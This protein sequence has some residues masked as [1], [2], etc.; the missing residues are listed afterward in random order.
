MEKTP[1]VSLLLTGDSKCAMMRRYA[2]K[3]QWLAVGCLN[4][5][6]CVARRG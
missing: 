5:V 4:G 1:A 3:K 6:R 2:E